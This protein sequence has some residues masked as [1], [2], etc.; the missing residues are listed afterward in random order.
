[1]TRK[2]F[3]A[4]RKKYATRSAEPVVTPPPIH[5]DEVV[6]VVSS[7]CTGDLL[8]TDERRVAH[9]GIE[10]RLPSRGAAEDFRERDRPVQ[11]V[12]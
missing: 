2:S 10:S 3:V 4:F 7:G 5:V 1:M 8:A 9:H 6:P 12:A 11:R